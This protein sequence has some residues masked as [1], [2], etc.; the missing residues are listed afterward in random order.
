MRGCMCVRCNGNR[1]HDLWP[2]VSLAVAASVVAH[3][4]TGTPLTRMFGQ[5]GFR[6]PLDVEMES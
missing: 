6:Q 4:V 5:I 2:A 1:R 3:G